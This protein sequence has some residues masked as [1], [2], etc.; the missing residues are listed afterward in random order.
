MTKDQK[1]EWNKA[2]KENLKK[3]YETHKD[4]IR[5]K[6]KKYREANKEKINERNKKYRQENKE[7]IREARKLYYQKN[8][9]KVKAKSQKYREEHKDY[10]KNYD[11]LYQNEKLANDPLFKFKRGVRHLIYL[12]FIRKGKTKS[13]RTENILG[14]TIEEFKEYIKGK[15]EEGMRFENYGEWHLDHVVPLSVAQTEEDV[16]KLCHYS[17]FQPL[18]AIDNLKKGKKNTESEGQNAV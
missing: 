13:T 11:A 10:Y 7:K 8:A 17:N 14:C 18:W 4:E 3:Y 15:F 6:A 5:E 2:H 16:I 1:R 9:E 12:S